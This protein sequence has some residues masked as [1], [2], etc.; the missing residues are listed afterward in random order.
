MQKIFIFFY[1]VFLLFFQIA[2]ADIKKENNEVCV[3]GHFMVT[4]SV[5]R[6]HRSFTIMTEPNTSFKPDR[7]FTFDCPDTSF[8][9]ALLTKKG[10]KMSVIVQQNTRRS[11]YCGQPDLQPIRV[12]QFDF[13]VDNN[14]KATITPIQTSA[15]DIQCSLSGDFN[16]NNGVIIIDYTGP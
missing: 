13:F 15:D 1:G 8:T 11:R 5:K 2:Y 9:F 3:T 12:C 6:T 10:M 7:I 16:L 4:Q 14:S